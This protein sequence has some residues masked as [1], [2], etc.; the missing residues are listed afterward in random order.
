MN[1]EV[2]AA[3]HRKAGGVLAE[4]RVL[5]HADEV[6]KGEMTADRARQVLA[7]VTIAM[8]IGGRRMNRKAGVDDPRIDAAMLV[9]GMLGFIARF[10]QLVASPNFHFPPANDQR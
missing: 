10:E 3:Q 2:L 5:R 9:H 6:A 7:E 1:L 4:A 8:T